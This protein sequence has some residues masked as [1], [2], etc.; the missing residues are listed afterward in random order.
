MEEE[1]DWR[2]E[3]LVCKNCVFF[4]GLS[5]YFP[6]KAKCKRV[7]FN[8]HWFSVPWF[9]ASSCGDDNAICSDFKPKEYLVYVNKHWTNVE[10]YL[11]YRI[12]HGMHNMNGH[13]LF[14]DRGKRKMS[15]DEQVYV[16]S[17]RD[18]YYG[19]MY[20]ENGCLRAYE[21]HYYRRDK[22]WYVYVKRRVPGKNPN[23]VAPIGI[24][25]V[26]QKL[27]DTTKE[28]AKFKGG[29]YWNKWKEEYML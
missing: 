13:C 26:Y 14:C 2:E 25:D 12:L 6:E 16:V 7:D 8:K 11:C 21:K 28:I 3:R 19:T 18:F 9:V 23:G 5:D 24:L 27:Y 17:Y 22:A 4:C 15:K 20:N 1:Y 29:E 10:D